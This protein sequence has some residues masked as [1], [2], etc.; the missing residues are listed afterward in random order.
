MSHTSRWYRP[1]TE[2]DALVSEL[3]VTSAVKDSKQPK[4]RIQSVISII[5]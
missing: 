1:G 3:T 4:L 2:N 5:I